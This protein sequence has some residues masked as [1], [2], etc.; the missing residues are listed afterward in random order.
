[1]DANG[2]VEKNL[3][4]RRRWVCHPVGFGF[5][6]VGV[7]GG[8]GGGVLEGSRG[9]PHKH[10]SVEETVF[11]VSWPPPPTTRS[12]RYVPGSDGGDR[13]ANGSIEGWETSRSGRWGG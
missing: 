13:I 9:S 3:L 11:V 4:Q 8:R 1:M 6:C 12:T 7:V 2:W 5:A 10:K